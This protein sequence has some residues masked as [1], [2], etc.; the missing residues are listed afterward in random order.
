[1]CGTEVNEQ[2]M[3]F[4][5]RS[6]LLVEVS[7]DLYDYEEDVHKNVRSPFC[8]ACISASLFHVVL[9]CFVCGGMHVH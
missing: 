4:L 9:R 6:E 7:D 5:D 2:F 1:M 3:D 8:E